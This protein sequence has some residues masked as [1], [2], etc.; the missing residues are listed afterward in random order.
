VQNKKCF[1]LG[2]LRNQSLLEQG[3]Q[4]IEALRS[5]VVDAIQQQI[6]ESEARERQA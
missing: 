5:Q 4:Q 6:A 2:H 1:E 3:Q